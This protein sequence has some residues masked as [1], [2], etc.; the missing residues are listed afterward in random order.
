MRWSATGT[1]VGLVV[2][3][4][5]TACASA[6]VVPDGP[7]DD[8]P[9]GTA[10]GDT[11]PDDTTAGDTDPDD[12]AE[13]PDAA[14]DA[15]VVG[16][17]ADL[18]PAFELLGDRFQQTTGVPIAFTFG[19]SGQLAQQLSQG[20][21]LDLYASA[22]AGYVDRVLAAGVGDETTRTTYAIGRIV[23]WSLDEELAGIEL[24]ELAERDLD[25]VAIANPEHAPYGRAA[26]EALHSAGVWEALE[27]SLVFG[28]NIAD[29]QRIAASGNAEVAIVALSLA[30]AAD[31][32]GRVDGDTVAATGH[33]TLLDERLHEPLEQDLLVTADDPDRATLAAQFAALVDSDEG[34]EVM[35]RFGLVPPGDDPPPSWNADPD[36]A[37]DP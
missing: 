30:L 4:A 22:D 17:A 14:A 10:P 11:D 18:R 26:R 20:A 2:A 19:S 29:A 6:P 16:A 13:L 34:R 28:E 36:A 21:P 24:S 1:I 25:A 35:R 8:T 9:D 7:D 33:W 31:G 37:A 3:T 23:L 27:P 12:T 32:T 5:L 15:L